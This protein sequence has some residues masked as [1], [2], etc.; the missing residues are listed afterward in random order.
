MSQQIQGMSQPNPARNR[1]S[2]EINIKPI[3]ALEEQIRDHE[4]TIV[5]L[6]RARNALLNIS[7]LPP[8]VLGDI[9]RRNVTLKDDFGKLK[10]GSHNFLFVCHHWFEVAS[11]T[12]EVWS[13]WGNTPVDWARRHRHPG[14]APLDLVLGDLRYYD[15]ISDIALRDAL[16]DRAARD[17]VRRVHLRSGN[18]ASLSSIIAPLAAAGEGIR[19][20]SVESFIL[21]LFSRADTAVDVSDFFARYCF[22]KLKRLELL[23]CRIT[24]WDLMHMSRTTGLTTLVLHFDH[25]SPPPTTPQLLSILASNPSL[26]KVSLSER[27]VPEDGGGGSPCPVPLR[28]LR[29]LELAGG[30]RHVIGLLHRLDH[31]TNV[32]LALTLCDRTAEDI[33]RIV[34]PYIRDYLRRRERSQGGLGLS[35]IRIGDYTMVRVGDMG[36]IDL[37]TRVWDGASTFVSIGLKPNETP[38]DPSEKWFLDL[39]AHIP[40]DEIISLHSWGEPAVMGSVPTQFPNLRALDSGLVPLSAVFPES[41]LGG[42]DRIPL[43]LRRIDLEELV[44]D[45]GDWSPLTTFLTSRASSGSQLDSLRVVGS[46]M[47]PSV[48]GHVRSMVQEFTV[49][50]PGQRCPFGTCP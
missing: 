39:V 33:T 21:D 20:N 29:K 14:T 36:G 37:S 23:K 42:N 8:E 16:Q 2:G 26:R 34:G 44:V 12:P 25:P 3:Q 18:A 38:Q 5:E 32:D 48:E 47:C 17:A 40:Q 24:S 50:G 13:F 30:L 43:S 22:P 11:R 49:K 35:A 45:G 46:H 27:A 1:L 9:F 41:N 31:P 10:K 7:T 28:H 15:R 6:K 19:S 4:R